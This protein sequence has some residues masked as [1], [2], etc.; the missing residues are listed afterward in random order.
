MDVL[1]L[2]DGRLQV[3]LK[4]VGGN[5]M[6]LQITYPREPAYR[7]LVRAA[8]ADLLLTEP[9]PGGSPVEPAQEQAYQEQAYAESLS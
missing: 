9:A 2:A 1:N 5:Q 4:D 6:R 3:S 7:A 8:I